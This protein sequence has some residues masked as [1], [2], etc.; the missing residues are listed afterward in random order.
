MGPGI[1]EVGQFDVEIDVPDEVSAWT[2][3]SS[4]V[5]SLSEVDTEILVAGEIAQVGEG[6]DPVVTIRL[7][8]DLLLVEIPGVK[9]VP[10]LAG[11]LSFQVPEIR[12]Y[13]YPL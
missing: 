4:A 9:P 12:L 10:P 7:G 2:E 5:T 3:V 13:P 11:L 1:A 6:D 8:T